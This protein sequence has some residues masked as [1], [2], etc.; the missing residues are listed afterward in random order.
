LRVAC[1]WKCCVSLE[2]TFFLIWIILILVIAAAGLGLLLAQSQRRLRIMA[3][4]LEL[5][6]REKKT[7]FEF[8]DRIGSNLTA[9]ADGNATMELIVSFAQDATKADAAALFLVEQT[10]PTLRARIVKGLFPPLHKLSSDKIFAKRKYL[11]D[12]IM[13]ETIRLGEGVVGKVA[14]SGAGLLIV[15]VARDS[16]TA[17]AD[18]G[19]VDVRDMLLAPLSVRAESLGVLVLVNK[20]GGGRFNAVDQSLVSAIANQAAVTLDLVRLWRLRA[21]Q[22]RMEH[23]LELARSFQAMLLPRKT[24]RF[25]A[26]EL[27]GFYQPAQEVGGDY[28]DFI[29]IDDRSLGIVIADVSGKGIPGA[30][31]MAAVRATLHAEARLSRSPKVVLQRVND[32]AARDTSDSVFITMTYAVLDLQTGI[33]RFCRAGHEPVLCCTDGDSEVKSYAPEGIALGVM[34]GSVFGVTQEQEIQLARG[35]TVLL[36]TDGVTEAVD[37]DSFEYG[38]ARVRA[39]L[40]A[41]G[42]LGPQAL[43]DS[44]VAGVEKFSAGMPQHDDMTMVA[45]R[46]RGHPDGAL[47]TA[48]GAAIEAGDSLGTK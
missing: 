17:D 13:K 28:Y 2:E 29:E 32:Q 41:Q 1:P 4:E 26:L 9:G 48:E 45:L 7:V 35:E 33:F 19:G 44:I 34:E 16:H 38:E 27:A 14:A 20:Q 25:E 39:G 40:I 8:L 36:Y 11:A 12:L 5:R 43:L 3:Y 46:W 10:S 37:R 30:L 24:P 18:F 15:D 21:E 31:V 23:E 47:S 6:Q 22:Q 42:H